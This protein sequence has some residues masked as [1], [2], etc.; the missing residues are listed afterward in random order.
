MNIN[1]KIRHYEE[2]SVNH[3]FY[4]GEALKAWVEMVSL[5]TDLSEGSNERF[6]AAKE[7]CELNRARAR[8]ELAKLGTE[9]ETLGTDD[10]MGQF[11]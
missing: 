6:T 3:S 9:I 5:L 2:V 10:K 4:V 1:N 7:R 11:E 8:Q